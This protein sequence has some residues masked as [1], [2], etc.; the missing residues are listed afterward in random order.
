M[1]RSQMRDAERD[2]VFRE[3]GEEP[4]RGNQERLSTLSG[5]VGRALLVSGKQQ[6]GKGKPR[7]I[8][9][10]QRELGN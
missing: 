3:V 1:K 8:E 7:A 5:R 9:S 10:P 6:K 4:I 2:D